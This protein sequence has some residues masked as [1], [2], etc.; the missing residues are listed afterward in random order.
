MARH[1]DQGQDVVLHLVNLCGEVAI[2]ELLQEL[3]LATD[4]LLL[5]LQRDAAAQRVDTPA[6]GGGHQP[7]RRVIRDAR[8]RP[9]L[10]GGDQRVLGQVLGNRHV[11]HDASQPGDQPG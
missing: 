11:A 2:V 5:A 7:R 10:Q 6:P 9:L 8:P 4:Q 3:K 1:E